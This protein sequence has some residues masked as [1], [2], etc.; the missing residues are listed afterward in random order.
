MLTIT[1]IVL[2]HDQIVA[3]ILLTFVLM[4]IRAIW[5]QVRSMN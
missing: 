4:S 5:F 2:T 3:L 1:P